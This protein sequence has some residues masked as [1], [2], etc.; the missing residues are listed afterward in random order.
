M[1]LGK[2]KADTLEHSTAGSL[3]TQYVVNG[4]AKAYA[5]AGSSG[6]SLG[7]SLNVSSLADE[8]T[9]LYSITFTN[10]M[11]AVPAA[12]YSDAL[13][14]GYNND[15]VTTSVVK[16]QSYNTSYGAADSANVYYT[17]HGDLA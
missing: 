16:S 2:I 14:I 10:N 13:S 3:D 6:N 17:V 12:H 5:H 8:A 7:S 1:A 15:P 9:G 11:S 4:S